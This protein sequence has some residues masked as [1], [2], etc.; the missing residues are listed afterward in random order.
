M[1]QMI[2]EQ[3]E[4]EKPKWC[5]KEEPA[6]VHRGWRQVIR[7]Q[8]VTAVTKH[9]DAIDVDAID[10]RPKEWSIVGNPLMTLATAVMKEK[11]IVICGDDTVNGKEI[12]KHPGPII[13]T[14]DITGKEQ[15]WLDVGSGVFARTFAQAQ[16]LVTTTRG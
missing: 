9:D 10:G 11:N 6:R 2:L 5:T 16:R 1:I 3:T 7:R 8:S 13:E 15:Q 4:K 12:R 14:K